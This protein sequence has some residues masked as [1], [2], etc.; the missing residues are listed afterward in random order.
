MKRPQNKIIVT[1]IFLVAILGAV[2]SVTSSVA[3]FYYATTVKT[4]YTG[5]TINTTK[6]LSLSLDQVEN[7]TQKA[8]KKTVQNN[9]LGTT[10]F[11]P[12]IAGP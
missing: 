10:N 9:V 3:W 12:V 2:S 11:V 1:S 4:A 6:L 8:D 5:T 7:F